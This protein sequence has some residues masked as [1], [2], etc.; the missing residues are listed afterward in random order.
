MQRS[1]DFLFIIQ[2]PQI[3]VYYSTSIYNSLHRKILKKKFDS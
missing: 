3:F 2:R 1:L